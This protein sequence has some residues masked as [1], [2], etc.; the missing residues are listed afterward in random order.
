MGKACYI[1]ELTN[2]T[3]QMREES[4]GDSGKVKMLRFNRLKEMRIIE[5]N[6]LFHI[7]MYNSY[8]I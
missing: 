6:Y 5:D 7:N 3:N 8:G 2:F 4:Q 1:T